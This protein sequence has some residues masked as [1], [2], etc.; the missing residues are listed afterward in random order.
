MKTWIKDILKFLL[1]MYSDRNSFLSKKRVESGFAF[2]FA[3]GYTC[4]YVYFQRNEM[5]IYEFG[6][7]LTTWLFIAGYTVNQIQKEKL[8]VPSEQPKV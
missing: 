6:Y 7:V 2:F 3:L 1:G 8:Q 4:C 5:S